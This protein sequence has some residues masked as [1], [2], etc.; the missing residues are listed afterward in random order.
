MFSLTSRAICTHGG[1][2]AGSGRA[3]GALVGGC[4]V[5]GGA[6][7]HAASGVI[8]LASRTGLR[9]SALGLGASGTSDPRRHAA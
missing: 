8:N 7:A 3:A 5:G 1:L 6:V 4:R 9:W 2:V